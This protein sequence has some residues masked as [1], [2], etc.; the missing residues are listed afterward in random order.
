MSEW[1]YKGG[2][3]WYE[4]DSKALGALLPIIENEGR[5]KGIQKEKFLKCINK[6]FIGIIFASKTL[7]D[8]P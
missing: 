3:A 8:E 5:E 1:I 7:S 4:I 6:K 2:M